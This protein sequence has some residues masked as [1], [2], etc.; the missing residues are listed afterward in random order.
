MQRFQLS[1]NLGCFTLMIFLFLSVTFSSS[2]LG[3]TPDPPPETSSE[4]TAKEECA[5]LLQQEKYSELDKK[6]NGWQTD[7]ELGKIN[8]I[9]MLHISRAFYQATPALED[10]YNKWVNEYPSSY[11]AKLARGIYFMRMA[12]QSRGEKYISQTS[13]DRISKMNVY[14]HKS[15][16]DLN[17]SLK[18]SNKPIITLYNIHYIYRL[19]G[20][21]SDERK[22]LDSSVQID[23]KNF[24]VRYA[25]MLGLQ[26]RW[27]GN[28]QQ[29]LDFRSE[30]Q[31]DG[32]S[33]DLVKYLDDL[34]ITEKNWL[35]KTGRN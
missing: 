26:T 31:G 23:P 24:I 30:A 29:M 11:A 32:L 4:I 19:S 27:G 1:K 16:E 28:L 10:K 7:Y 34:I 17:S 18:F 33:D 8:D 3:Y 9:N 13:H 2:A 14:L 20:Q 6:F 5:I 22:V 25:H 21:L 12:L 35:A 15:I